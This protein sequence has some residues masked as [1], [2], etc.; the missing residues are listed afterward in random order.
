MKK[1]NKYLDWWESIPVYERIWLI[2]KY[3]NS[4]YPLE[5]S[6]REIKIVYEKELK[7]W[8]EFDSLPRVENSESIE[9][10]EK[11]TGH[12]FWG[13]PTTGYIYDKDEKNNY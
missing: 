6:K 2:K 12:G 13:N 5:L 8:D 4:E 11:R 3:Y 7:E 1:K 9:E 10:I